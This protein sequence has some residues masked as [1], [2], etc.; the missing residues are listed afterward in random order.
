MFKC[1]KTAHIPVPSSQP[2]Q[3]GRRKGERDV[4]NPASSSLRANPGGPEPEAQR[5]NPDADTKGNQECAPDENKDGRVD[6]DQGAEQE[7]KRRD[8]R[9]RK[10]VEMER[11][12]R[13]RKTRGRQSKKR[14]K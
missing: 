13:T 3:T 6:Q 2:L 8:G 9:E 1:V 11:G 5:R 4:L 10:E 7:T 12:F 14:E